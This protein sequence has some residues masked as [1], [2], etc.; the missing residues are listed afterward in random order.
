MEKIAKLGSSFLRL[1]FFPFLLI[2]GLSTVFLPS[3]VGMENLAEMQSAKVIEQF[4]SIVGLTVF[5]PLYIPDMDQ[6][7]LDMIRTKRTPYVQIILVRLGLILLAGAV[8]LLM[9]LLSLRRHHSALD[10]SF[11][12]F[13]EGANLIFLGSLSAIV[14][15]W[16]KHP[17]PSLMVPLLYFIIN[18]FS[19]KKQLGLLYFFTLGMKDWQSKFFLLGLGIVFLILS[20][21]VAIKGKGKRE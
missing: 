7:T 11:F 1:H 20:I 8:L 21:A 6:E 14:F 13:G 12:F 3:L 16:T 18:L 17:V 4:F 19:S 9:F 5:L 2:G 10:F 15:A